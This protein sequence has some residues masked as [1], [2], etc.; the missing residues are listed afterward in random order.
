MDS[1][2]LKNMKKTQRLDACQLNG[3]WTF[4]GHSINN[5]VKKEFIIIRGPLDGTCFQLW[6]T[7]DDETLNIVSVS[8]IRRE[9]KLIS[10]G[11]YE[12]LNYGHELFLA[13]ENPNDLNSTSEKLNL[14]PY[15][16][17][18]AVWKKVVGGKDQW[19]GWIHHSGNMHQ[20]G[21]SPEDDFVLMNG[22]KKELPAINNTSKEN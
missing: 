11:R 14:S 15:T 16:R 10:S 17:V 22:L 1:K 6:P 13:N 12:D 7:S 3:E 5:E 8:D 2:I 19:L 9:D 4:V 20:I 21:I 18:G